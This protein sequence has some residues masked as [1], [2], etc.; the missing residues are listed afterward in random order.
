MTDGE[1]AA[2]DCDEVNQ[3]ESEQTRTY[4]KSSNTQV[5]FYNLLEVVV[6]QLIP[7][8]LTARNLSTK[9]TNLPTSYIYNN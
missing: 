2:D 5:M 9:H 7:M 6:Y 4:T 8:L 1:N 3:E